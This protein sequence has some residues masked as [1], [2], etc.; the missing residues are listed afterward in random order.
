LPLLA[1][2]LQKSSVEAGR[3]IRAVLLGQQSGRRGAGSGLAGFV[4]GA[5]LGMVATLQAT[6]LVNL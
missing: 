2:W 3:R 1:A 6:A 4:S 5:N